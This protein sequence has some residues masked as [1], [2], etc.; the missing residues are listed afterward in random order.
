L[1]SALGSVNL[2]IAVNRLEKH[3]I[4]TTMQTSCAEMPA[5]AAVDGPRLPWMRLPE[6][7]DGGL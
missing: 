4:A 1:I 5:P 3:M 6:V 2:R 7:C